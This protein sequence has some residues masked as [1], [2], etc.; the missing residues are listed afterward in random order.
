MRRIKEILDRTIE[1]IRISINKFFY[2]DYIIIS[3][4]LLIK[5]LFQAI[6]LLSGYKWMSADDYCRTVIS[7]EWLQQPRIYSGVWL[8][9]HFWINGFVMMFIKDL[10]TAATC[11]NFVFS[12]FTLIFF[13]KVVQT[14]FDRK[15]AFW[16][17]IIF[18]L[19]PFQV[20]LSIS[21]LPESISYFFIISSLYYFIKWKKENNI[22]FLIIASLLIALSSGFRYEAWLFCLTIPVLTLFYSIK[23]KNNV[24][25]IILN[26]LV[27]CISFF[28]IIWWLIQN[29]IDNKDIFFFIKETERIYAKF[30]NSGFLERLI[31]YPVFL[32]YTA[33]ITTIFSLKIIYEVI[34]EKQTSLKTCFVLFNLIQLLFLIIQGIFGT[35]GTNLVSRYIIINGILLIPLAIEQYFRFK[36]YVAVFALTTTIV[37]YIIWSL[38]FPVSNREDTYEVGYKM[39]YQI[40]E[41]LKDEKDKIYFEELSGFYDIY[42][43]QTLSNEPTRFIKGNLPELVKTE[44][45]STKKQK[46][47]DEELNILD[48]KNFLEKN[49]VSIAIVKSETYKNKLKK[50]ALRNDEVGDYSLYYFREKESQI[51]DSALTIFTRNI[52]PLSEN[53]DL[54]NFGKLLALK[55]YKIDNTNYGLNPQFVSLDWESVNKAIIDSLDYEEFEL[56]RYN[57][58]LELLS[59]KKDTVV[60]REVKRIFSDKNIEDLIDDNHFRTIMIIKPFALLQYSIKEISN[61]FESGIYYLNL[62]I[63]DNKYNTDLIVYKGDSLFKYSPEEVERGI[64]ITRD[65]T[66][67]ILPAKKEKSDKDTV[68]NSYNLGQILALFPNT[69]FFKLT[70][71]GSFELRKTIFL[72]EFRILFSQRYQGDQILNLIFSAF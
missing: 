19:F 43:I 33:P 28:V 18:S 69:D 36:R 37:L 66:I 9:M 34:K 2:N 53:P 10:F 21:G 47:T 50:I 68:I 41:E 32:F 44:K 57:I 26:T 59:E 27:S 45:K 8:S 35:G 4:L 62:K 40:K 56:E 13:F 5:I 17:S 51:S 60:H 22:K 46:L 58:I 67:K 54:I 11:V 7:Y 31:Q 70:Q 39:R 72:N 16:A 64:E 3:F 38:N 1:K 42:T 65:T 23:E 55:G 49:N 20:W 24:K 71:K 6:I 29:Y 25:Y 48:I 63:R 30:N 15:I 14:T 12:T 52:K 61:P